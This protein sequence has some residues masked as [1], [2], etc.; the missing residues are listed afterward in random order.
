[1]AERTGAPTNIID[2]VF[3]DLPGQSLDSTWTRDEYLNVIADGGYPEALTL[4]DPLARDA[5]YSGYLTTIINR[6]I[7]DFANIHN[8][9]ALP[10]VLALIAARAGSTLVQS[11]IAKS[12]QMSWETTRSYIS[13]L[14]MVFLTLTVPAWSSNLT[15]KIT[16]TPKVF[17]SDSGLAA[18]LLQV[19]SD[20]L[21]T[22]PALGN[23]VETFVA[24]ELTKLLTFAHRRIGLWH[25]RD[26]G[27]AEVDFILEGPQ[28]AIVGVEVK[29]TVSPRAESARHL[30]W[31][32]DKLG[33]RFV[34]GVVFHL[35]Q[36]AGSFGDGIYTLPLSTLWN[37][38]PLP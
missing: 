23:L 34:G 16:K 26:S 31:L 37:H 11:D 35:G 21:G 19:D 7:S 6:D 27:G 22:S 20:V 24:T 25:F 32:R 2:R 30:R 36:Q 1:M 4:R 5:W 14:D 15:S 17:V 18:H 8:A 38:H 9:S 10:R 3:N 29:A 12:V 13:Y 28:G 33:D